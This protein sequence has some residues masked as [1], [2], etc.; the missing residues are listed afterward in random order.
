MVIPVLTGWNYP[1]KTFSNLRTMFIF[2]CIQFSDKSTD[3][4]IVKL[5]VNTTKIILHS[6]PDNCL[7][8]AVCR[9]QVCRPG[10]QT[11]TISGVL[12]GSS[13]SFK[14]SPQLEV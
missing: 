9:E 12:E 11:I 14:I 3:R 13:G 10:L 6:N 5:R 2:Q 1:E 4:K 7:H 8:E